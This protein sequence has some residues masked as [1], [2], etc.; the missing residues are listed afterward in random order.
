MVR[1]REALVTEDSAHSLLAEYFASREKSTANYVTTFP[2]P[3]RFVSPEGV[4]LIV[5]SDGV[6]VG[7]GGIR[8]LDDATYEITHVWLQPHTRG[9]GLGRKLLTELERR[10]ASLGATHVVLDTNS[11]QVAAGGLYRAS[12][13]VEVTPYND[14]ANADLW[15]RKRISTS[16]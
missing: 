9:Q 14:N 12:G 4:F 2:D 5:E 3:A 13:Y 1:Y 6:D 11:S 8:R 10:A 7:C 15:M 16:D